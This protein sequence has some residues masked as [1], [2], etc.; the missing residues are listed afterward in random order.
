VSNLIE[1][2]RMGDLIAEGHERY[3]LVVI[4]TPPTSLVPDA[5]PLMGAV[6][7][8]LVVTR[9]GRT[10][11]DEVRFLTSQLTHIG[12][13]AVGVVVNSITAQDGYYGRAYGEFKRAG[14]PVSPAP[15]ESVA[16]RR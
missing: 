15:G 14:A 13:P 10:T 3:D 9:L 8:V 16:G 7:G 5:I 2:E 11:R 12:A 1:S 6:S 4:D